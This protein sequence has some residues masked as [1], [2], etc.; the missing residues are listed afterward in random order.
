VHILLVDDNKLGL[1]ARKIV[2][3]ELGYRISP[4]TCAREAL[5]HFTRHKFDLVITDYK[6]PR[7]DGNELIKHLRRERPEI[8]I[9]LISGF[10]DTLGLDEKSTGADIVIQ[11]SNHEVAN[12]IHSVDRL[13]NRK[14]P[15]K[16]ARAQAAAVR[17]KSGTASSWRRES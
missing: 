16:P 11:K 3:E 8:P 5:D 13:L 17:A 9:I 10:A 7:M 14:V 1:S 2:L 15:K 6:M 12:L 4:F